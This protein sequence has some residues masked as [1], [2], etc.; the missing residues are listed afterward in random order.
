MGRLNACTGVL[1]RPIAQVRRIGGARGVHETHV[2]P[3]G[4]SGC[5][6]FHKLPQPDFIFREIRSR[7]A[8]EEKM[9]EKKSQKNRSKLFGRALALLLAL[10]LT[11]CLLPAAALAEGSSVTITFMASSAGEIFTPRHTMTVQAG[12]AARYGYSNGA[13]VK[14]G[15]VTILDAIVQAHAD[16]YGSAFT[17]ADA[18]GRETFLKVGSSG[19]ITVAFQTDA[20]YSTQ[21]VNGGPLGS[22]TA[23]TAVL[24]NG[25]VVE[26]LYASKAAYGCDY[27][28]YFALG[29]TQVNELTVPAGTALKLTLMGGTAF[30]KVYP[31][32]Y[33][34]WAPKA[35]KDL[36]SEGTAS[37]CPIDSAG[38][39]GAAITGAIADDGTVTVP[40]ISEGYHSFTVKGTE[41]NGTFPLIMPCLK[42]H[43]VNSSADTT[44]ENA[45]ENLS[46]TNIRGDN[47]RM[48]AVTSN[49][50]LP[51]SFAGADISWSCTGAAGALSV[52]GGTAYVDRPAAAD[53]KCTLTASLSH[54]GGS[55]VTKSLDLTV[56]AEG[57]TAS[58]TV[59][60]FGSLITGIAA[61]Y[62]SS[63][64]AWAVMDM[65]AY[66]SSFVG[67]S[68]YVASAE[69][70]T[71]A[72]N[73]RY[74][75]AEAAR[76]N[77]ASKYIG[78]LGTLD[79]TGSYAIYTIPYVLLAYDAYPSGVVSG[80]SNTRDT[81]VTAMVGYLN[82]LSANYAGV[83]EVAPILAA[84]AKY[85]TAPAYSSL[86]GITEANYNAVRKAVAAGITWLSEQQN[87][88]GSWSYYGTS[89]ADSTALAVVALSALGID[90]HTDTRFIKNYNSAVEG[91]MSFALADNSGFGYKGN[92]TKNVLATEQGFRALVSYARF[93]NGGA[94]YN[95]YTGANSATDTDPVPAPDI[96]VINP[97]APV[98]PSTDVTVTFSLLGDAAHGAGGGT[99][100][101][102]GGNL[103]SWIG[104]SSITVSSGSSVGDVFRK[105][106]DGAGYK[107][108]G[109]DKGY[110]S[111]ITSPSGVTLSSQTNGANSGWMYAVNGSHP[112][113][114]LNDYTLSSGD[115][116]VFHYTDDYLKESGMSSAGGTGTASAVISPD[117]AV[118]GN[119]A[120]STVTG[121]QVASAVKAAVAAADTGIIIV[122]KNTGSAASVSVTI[123]VSAANSVADAKLALTADTASGSV[124]IPGSALSS[125]ASRAF[126]NDITITVEKKTAADVMD[127][128]I[129]TDGAVIAGVTVTCGGNAITDF[130]GSSLTVNLPVSGTFAEGHSYKV[131]EISADGAEQVLSGRCVSIG[132]RLYVQFS[133]SHLS[134][135]VVLVGKAFAD[136]G[137]TAWYGKAA[138]YVS[139]RGLMN[140]TG[141]DIFSPEK[142]MTR[143]MLVTA[144]YRLEGC[145]AVV[146]T[147]SGFSD[148]REGDWFLNAVAWASG[149][150]IAKGFGGGRFGANDPVTREQAAAI[151]YRYAQYKNQAAAASADL[152]AFSDSGSVSAWAKGAVS[153]CVFQGI[154]TGRASS[155]LSPSAVMSRAEAAAVLMRF[156]EKFAQ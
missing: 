111:S 140:G 89:N 1:S 87:D 133:V 9:K 96:S 43:A 22:E 146:Q 120:V 45:A 145:P 116:I 144:L 19:F 139:G 58:Q 6:N 149:A 47:L 114:G 90:A 76:G 126:G 154:I 86:L 127:K 53:A 97:P 112:G 130:G 113:V 35:L 122:P 37:L 23:D 36:S 4:K 121:Q 20:S 77:D 148:C 48:D 39:P 136:V 52:Y 119:A 94:A 93:K 132:G 40:A 104:A 68:A 137:S 100:T 51:S 124:T 14:S 110:V 79:L 135:F 153:W 71:G 155:V 31:S 108:V 59:A 80:F 75:L 41:S 141:S 70:P 62:A 18:A 105:V 15:D 12:T 151:L 81:L 28:A 67:D 78:S 38:S 72:D 138:E 24:Q 147:L 128:S 134:T 63:A 49:L 156:C 54:N 118:S 42:I 2:G 103:T 99:H 34:P 21:L 123:P 8:R 143:A 131:I 91:L 129:D 44:A 115:V 142:A 107:Y 102:S 5:G 26:N 84:L 74:G 88:S 66:N 3:Q 33:G 16:K 17:Q 92:V 60:S 11:V 85:Y 150:G 73:A 57:V 152:A 30:S 64:D 46:W 125:I 117:S 50:T 69:A 25:D 98:I 32:Y 61:T 65:E 95:I 109:L 83:D 10:A 106:L 13:G 7:Q 55:P 27:Y 56:K 29:E 101:L 82:G